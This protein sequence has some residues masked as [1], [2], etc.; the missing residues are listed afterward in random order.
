MP[1]DVISKD[2]V[3]MKRG[4]EDIHKTAIWQKTRRRIIILQSIMRLST[5]RSSEQTSW[6]R[7]AASRHTTALIH[8]NRPSLRCSSPTAAETVPSNDAFRRQ[9][10][11]LD[12]VHRQ[13]WRLL[14]FPCSFPPRVKQAKA[15]D[16]L[17]CRMTADC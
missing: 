17:L 7:S 9:N 1:S 8:H 12:E 14:W 6:T 5:V 11:A 2:Y 16:G 4:A 13:T 15:A 10:R 3:N